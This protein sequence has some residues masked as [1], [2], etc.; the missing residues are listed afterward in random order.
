MRKGRMVRRHRIRHN[1]IK[2]EIDMNKMTMKNNV[3]VN[4]R[5]HDSSL[6]ER[7]KNYFADNAMTITAGFLAVNSDADMR[8]FCRLMTK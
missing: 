8:E 7:L 4:G 1:V 6:K 5:S 2:G 3:S